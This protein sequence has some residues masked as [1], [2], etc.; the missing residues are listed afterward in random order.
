MGTVRKGPE[1][2]GRQRKVQEYLVG[3]NVADVMMMI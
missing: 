3:V 1:S 2:Y